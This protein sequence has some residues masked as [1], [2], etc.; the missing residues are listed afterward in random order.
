MAFL[1]GAFELNRATAAPVSD[2]PSAD[3]NSNPVAGSGDEVSASP[4][5]RVVALLIF[6]AGVSIALYLPETKPPFKAVDGF[7]LLTGFF[8][9]AQAIERFLELAP[10]VGS[11]TEQSKANRSIVISAIAFVLAVLLSENLG[12]FLLQ[13]VGVTAVSGDLDV[14]ITALAISGGTKSLHDFIKTIEKVKGNPPA[15]T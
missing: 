4:S 9:A 8:I 2:Q 14:M 11:G 13:A 3:P 12:L 5:A 10:V 1:D 6:L 15:T 7:I